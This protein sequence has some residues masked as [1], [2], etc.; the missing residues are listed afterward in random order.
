MEIKEPEV[1]FSKNY[2]DFGPGFYLT[3][4]QNQ[5][6]KWAK[7]KSLRKKGIATVNV[8]E[9][10]EDLHK[11]RV[12]SFSEENEQWL[13]F[14]CACRK[15]EEI[16]KE[17]DVIIGSVADDDVFRTVDF[18]FRGIW[19]KERALEELRYYKMN[20]QICILSQ[21]VIDENLTFV[22]SYEL[23]I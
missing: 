12:L 22:E 8:Y 1:I 9:L 13:D 3:T 17:Y 19:S 16:Y 4:F 5:T 2:L 18:Y 6:E 10:N 15:G 20:D 7:R 14:V 21:K 11:Y 23:K